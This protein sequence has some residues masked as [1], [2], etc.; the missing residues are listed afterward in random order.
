[1]YHGGVLNGEINRILGNLRHT[2]RICIADCGLPLPEGVEVVDLCVRLGQPS[3]LAVLKEITEHFDAEKI[4]LADEIEEQNQ[5][6]YS[7]LQKQFADVSAELVPHEEF[8][9]LTGSC[10]AVI[11]TGENHPY[12]NIILQSSCIF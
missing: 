10:A 11:R 1:M 3:F 2:D 5:T 12:A 8:K 9:R 6:L 7:A 4:V